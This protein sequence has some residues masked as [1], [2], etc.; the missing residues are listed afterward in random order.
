MF[1]TSVVC[2][3]LIVLLYISYAYLDF[4]SIKTK[5]NALDTDYQES[6][7]IF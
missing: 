5:H 1:K 3:I 2:Q 6:I 7:Q 4:Y